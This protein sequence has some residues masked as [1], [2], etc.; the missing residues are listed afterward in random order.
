MDAPL[1]HVRLPEIEISAFEMV[2]IGLH[3]LHRAAA[4]IFRRCT[5]LAQEISFHLLHFFHRRGIL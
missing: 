4:G 3:L 2:P 1:K 5:I